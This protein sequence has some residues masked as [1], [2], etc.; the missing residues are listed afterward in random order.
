MAILMVSYSECFS[1]SALI[2]SRIYGVDYSI[3]PYYGC[4]HS[5]VYCYARFVLKVRNEDPNKWGSFVCA[6]INAPKILKHEIVNARRGLVLLSSVTDPY[7]P[8]E[9]KYKLTR[10]IL[11]ILQ[12]KQFPIVI[13]TK[14]VFV[15]RDIDLLKLFNDAEV[16]L[17]I[18]TLDDEIASIFE[19]KASSPTKRLKVLERLSTKLRT[20]AFIGP[21]LPIFSEKDIE[22]LIEALS[23]A[24]VRRILFDK[25]NL[26]ARNWES[27]NKALTNFE[28]HVRKRFWQCVKS[29]NYWLLVK[30]KI[31]NLAERNHLDVDFCY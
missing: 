23:E 7:Q 15:E 16:G 17:T 26:K 10:R 14:S 1:K 6:K 8:L 5:C 20:Y 4:E 12:K 18:T 29:E 11:E 21:Y 24:N 27:I 22:Y 3:N 13:L 30:K 31:K 25:L 2:K 28:S 19:P 9:L